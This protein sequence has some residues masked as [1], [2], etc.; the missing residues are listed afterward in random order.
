VIQKK[1]VACNLCGSTDCAF[2]FNAIDRLHGFDGVFTYV[3][4]EICGLV[5]MNPQVAA[6]EIIKLYPPDY[7][8]HQAK[9][10][11]KE[12][13]LRGLRKKVKRASVFAF[14]CE[15]LTRLSRLLDV[16]CGSGTFLS[17]MRTLT[18]CEV[19]G[20]DVSNLAAKTARQN[21]GIDTF[22]GSVLGSPFRSSYFDVITAWSYLEHINDPSRVLRKFSDLLKPDGWCV[23]KTPNFDSFNARLFKERWYHLDCPRHL[24]I[25]TP[26]TVAKLLE[27]SML[28]VQKVIYD[29]SSK[30]ILGSLQYCFYGDNYALEHRNRLRR[31]S[32]LKQVVSPWSRIA[33][34]LKQSDTVVVLAKKGRQ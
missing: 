7:G 1:Q 34:L 12:R 10:Q 5:Y 26:K 32:F 18:D 4:C 22:A 20:V 6:Q 2:L 28:S 15:K 29:R 31:S 30:G 24:Y 3:K 8:P 9:P 25:Y 33:A 13:D 19:Y 27:K 14:L 17:D 16:G 21:Y 23:I 11:T